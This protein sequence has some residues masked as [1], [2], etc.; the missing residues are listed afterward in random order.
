MRKL[1]AFLNRWYVRLI[2]ILVPFGLGLAGYIGYYTANEASSFFMPLYSTVRLFGFCFDASKNG[3]TGREWFFVI[4][5]IARWLAVIPTGHALYHLLRPLTAHFFSHVYFFLLKLRSGRQVI[6]VGCNN[7]NRLLYDSGRGAARLI[8]CETEEEFRSLRAGRYH[9]LRAKSAPVVRSLLRRALRSSIQCTVIVNTENDDANLLI[10]RSA[11]DL[12]RTELAGSVEQIRNLRKQPAGAEGV[13]GELLS[14]EDRLVRILDR[15]QIVA[16]GNDR[17]ESVYQEM[18]RQSMGVLRYTNACRIAAQDLVSKYPLTAFIDPLKIDARACVDPALDLNV[19]MIGF[20]ET[21]QEILTSS[22]IINQFIENTPD[23][24]PGI[25]RVH[26]HI[27]D[28]RDARADMN[29]NHLLFR[30]P[31]EFLGDIREGVLDED[32]FLELPDFPAELTFHQVDVSDPAFYSRFRSICSASPSSV[33][34]VCIAFSGDL[35]NIDLAHKLSAKLKEWSIPGVHLF[36][37][38]CDSRNE[39]LFGTPSPF[40][41]FGDEDG[42]VYNLESII[43]GEMLEM[44][45]KKHYMNTLI[46]SRNGTGFEGSEKEIEIHSKYEW[47]MLDS[48]KKYSSLYS[49]L[50]IRMK[51]QLMGLDYVRK[52]DD[53]D[54]SGLRSN[55]EYFGIYAGD[56]RP[57]VDRKLETLRRVEIYAYRNVL[58]L[59]DFRSQT[60][61][62][63]LLIQEHLRWNAF[64]LSCGFVPASREQILS[65]RGKDYDLRLHGNLTT[66]AGLVE[67]REL[68]TKPGESPVK[69]DVINYDFHQMDELWWYLDLF[70]Y[71]IIRRKEQ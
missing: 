56:D 39:R 59:D 4:L 57:E 48:L 31:L 17:F 67:Y 18:E 29:L 55:E 24:I 9:A 28:R 46:R 49:I 62:K 22:F 50:A 37:R 51:L 20:G 12:L 36:V 19:L 58:G 3:F 13:S 7:G 38:V 15:I 45:R 11:V 60:L 34:A 14:R 44:A 23:G 1:S 47:Y 61:R 65:G 63:N 8:L 30:Y 26:Y 71:E 27:F 43:N 33:N 70:G 52:A 16:F 35:E 53:P 64:M 32:N 66:L 54:F 5:H 69:H 68:L 2:I 21:N 41:C 40:I 6:L 42:S 25:K 10:C